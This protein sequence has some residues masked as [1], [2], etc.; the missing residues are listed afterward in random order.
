MSSVSRRARAIGLVLSV[1]LGVVA[2]LLTVFSVVTEDVLD[3]GELV[4]VDDPVSRF[5]IG[6]RSAGVTVFMRV[7]TQCGSA[8]VV[9]P[10]LLGVG[11]FARRRRG[12]WRPL[13]FVAVV[14]VG[15]T[16]T[17]TLVKVLVARPRPGTG[18]LV[19]A[20]GYA[21]PSGHSTAAS[22]AWLSA[23]LVLG[24]LTR[25]LVQRVLLAVVAVLVVVL[26][27]VS[28]VYLGVHAPTDVLGGWAM[29][30]LWVAG[31]LAAGRQRWG[32][33]PVRDRTDGRQEV[34][35]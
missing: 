24:S 11:F 6:H 23:A 33:H 13:A 9:V 21:F 29:G 26:V 8:L 25:R 19:K 32:L 30:A 12:S 34:P 16:L 20:L 10:L 4:G 17:S 2:L 28:R 22:A 18:A 5:L 1:P 31:A 7:M 14:A 15:A 3:G 27:G 35:A